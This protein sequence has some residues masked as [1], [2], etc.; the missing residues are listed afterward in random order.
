[1][2]CVCGV[3]WCWLCGEH[4]EGDF[5]EHWDDE[6]PQDVDDEFWDEEEYD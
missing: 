1:M 3:D 4:L 6:H 5:D 2:T